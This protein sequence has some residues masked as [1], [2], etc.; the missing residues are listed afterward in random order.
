MGLEDSRVRY[1]LGRVSIAAGLVWDKIKERPPKFKF[2]LNFK[3]LPSEIT[4]KERKHLMSFEDTW[5]R[6]R[7]VRKI[8]SQ[9]MRRATQERREIL[10]KWIVK[11]WGGI[12]G[13]NDDIFQTWVEE[14]SYF[15]QPRVEKFYFTREDHRPSSWSKIIS[16]ADHK[17][18]PVYDARA[19]VALNVLL[20]G[21]KIE[22]RFH[23]P[24]TRNKE[25]PKAVDKLKDELKW[26]FD[27]RRVRYAYYREYRNLL[28]A[29]EKHAGLQ[30][31]LQVEMHLFSHSIPIIKDY[32]KRMEQGG[33]PSKKMENATRGKKS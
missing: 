28:R 30:D 31:V 11:D 1:P 27:G 4:S 12:R 14:L 22:G 29:I 23:M 15:D 10:F 13:G 33:K 7:E 24:E 8:I 2:N 5:E 19:T 3:N 26:K 18:Y 6:N 32:N 20:E 25:V 21:T 16:F 17:F 9:H